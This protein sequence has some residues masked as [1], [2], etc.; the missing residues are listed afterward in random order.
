MVRLLLL[1][2]IYLVIIAFFVYQLRD[3]SQ[4]E[5]QLSYSQQRVNELEMPDIF[6]GARYN[7]TFACAIITK[8]KFYLYMS[9]YC[10]VSC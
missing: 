10:R 2:A 7:L 1:T 4:F 3:Y 6:I 9:C 8:G 5:R